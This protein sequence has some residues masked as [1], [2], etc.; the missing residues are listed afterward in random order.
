MEFM[1]MNG[2]LVTLYY[3]RSQIGNQEPLGHYLLQNANFP[4]TFLCII[5]LLF[6]PSH[7][8]YWL[9]PHSFQAMG[10]EKSAIFVGVSEVLQFR[11]EGPHLLS[12]SPSVKPVLDFFPRVITGYCCIGLQIYEMQREQFWEL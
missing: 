9:L 5:L 11:I 7:P 1:E 3:K 8:S 10:N 6:S 2:N 4:G 12:S